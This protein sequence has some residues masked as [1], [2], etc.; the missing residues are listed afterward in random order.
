MRCECLGGP[1]YSALA[2]HRLNWDLKNEEENFRFRFSFLRLLLGLIRQ[3]SQTRL[4][5]H[6][7]FLRSEGKRVGV[8]TSETCARGDVEN[9]FFIFSPRHTQTYRHKHRYTSGQAQKFPFFFTLTSNFRRLPQHFSV[10]CVSRPHPPCRLPCA[11]AC[12]S[13][14]IISQSSSLPCCCCCLSFLL[15]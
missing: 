15:P 8:G 10:A 14:Y 5:F 9:G 12:V 4:L 1:I 2:P 13:E 6:S 3:H 7:A 11:N